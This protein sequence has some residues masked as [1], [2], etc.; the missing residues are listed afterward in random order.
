MVLI[1]L[2]PSDTLLERIR[3]VGPDVS[4]FS[5][6]LHVS[7]SVAADFPSQ[8]QILT[9]AQLNVIVQMSRVSKSMFIDVSHHV[10]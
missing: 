7:D 5:P 3:Q 4:Q 6:K 10:T 2:K 9:P 1:S 8:D